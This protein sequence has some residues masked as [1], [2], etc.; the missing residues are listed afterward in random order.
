MKLIKPS[1]IKPTRRSFL[2]L[3]PAVIMAPTLAE[4]YWQSRLQVSVG[5]PAGYFGPGDLRTFAGW[6]GI[7]GYSAAYAALGTNPAVDLLDQAGANPITIAILTNGNLDM[8]SVAT[9]VTAH[10]VT[11]IKVTQI[12][13]QTGNGHHLVEVTLASM[14][15]LTL[16]VFG[17]IPGMTFTAASSTKLAAASQTIGLIQPLMVSAVAIAATDGQ[18]SIMAGGGNLFAG[19]DASTLKPRMFAGSD[20]SLSSTTAG[21]KSALNYVFNGASSLIRLNGTSTP[22]SNPGAGDLSASANFFMGTDF[23]GENFDGVIAEAGCEA[24]T[25]GNETAIEANQRAYYGF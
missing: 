8:A 5:A 21:T 3:A 17:G 24:W 23:F 25:T 9:W 7:R 19:F 15:V 13:D 16:S 10:S 2:A 18:R 11:T 12:Y 14:P 1:L 22:I 4:A 6:W 20:V